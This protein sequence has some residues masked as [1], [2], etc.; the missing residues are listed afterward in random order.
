LLSLLFG[1]GFSNWSANLPVAEDLFDYNILIDGQREEDKI[2]QVRNLKKLWDQGHPDRN[3]E[4]FLQYSLSL[5]QKDQELVIWYIVRRVTDPFIWR[6]KWGRHVLMIDE[7]RRSRIEG[8]VKASA[9][10]EKCTHLSISGIITTNYDMLIEY[11]LGTRGFNYGIT[12][13]VLVG[14]G[15][16]P[17]S[18]WYHRVVLTGNIQLA[19]I[20]GSINWDYYAHYSDGRRGLT[21]SAKIIPPLPNKQSPPDL[22]HEWQLAK[23]ILNNS[24]RLL[25]FGFAFNDY[26]EAVIDLL[27]NEGT[28]LKSVLVVDKN[29]R[30][31]K[32]KILWPNA[33]IKSCQPPTQGELQIIHWLNNVPNKLDHYC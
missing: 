18:T 29:P 1:A 25:V 23:E 17:V 14:R 19:K 15:A 20:H 3:V 32:A 7:Y 8:V 28:K 10:I 4:N 26:D 30:I 6:D 13:E 24:D 21:G 2:E 9:F 33:S 11:S 27:S 22:I 16:Y 5:N 31:E 12:N